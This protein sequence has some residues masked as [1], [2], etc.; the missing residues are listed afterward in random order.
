MI[1]FHP[2]TTSSPLLP[3]SPPLVQAELLILGQ[4]HH[5]GRLGV[6]GGHGF[7][8]STEEAAGGGETGPGY[9]QAHGKDASG[10]GETEPQKVTSG[11][12]GQ[13]QKWTSLNFSV[14]P[15]VVSKVTG[16]GKGLSRGRTDKVCGKLKK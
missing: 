12:L 4:G 5:R 14:A 2:S 16:K 10:G 3:P 13:Y 9:G 7:L 8:E 1:F 11:R 15:T 6:S